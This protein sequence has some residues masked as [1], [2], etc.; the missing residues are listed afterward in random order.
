MAYGAGIWHSPSSG[1]KKPQ[2]IASKLGAIQ[3]KSL[4]TV[5]G[6]YKATPTRRVEVETLIPPIHVYLDDLTARFK[7]RT[8][9]TAADR[10]IQTAC[11]TIRDRLRKRGRGRNRVK[12]PPLTPQQFK[13]V[14]AK[15]WA[16]NADELFPQPPKAGKK[17]LKLRRQ[18]AHWKEEIRGF[19]DNSLAGTK[20]QLDHHILDLHDGLRKAEST[21]I[22]QLRTG[23]TGL[24]AVLRT[25]N[26]PG[27]D[28]GQ[29]KCGQGK[30]T[31]RHV[32]A[33]C[34]L[35]ESR[36]HELRNEDGFIDVTNLLSTEKGAAK[37]ARWMIS[38]GRLSQFAL[39]GE[40]L[41]S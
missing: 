7:E 17:L 13:A 33:H 4:R 30:E 23:Y 15:E 9:D 27:F 1:P 24:A 35:E 19:K 10:V 22:I 20:L 5:A 25:L 26:V 32:L 34:S 18:L 37:A 28:T 12:N 3:N 14:W 39:A 36:R 29:C 21:M 38:S 11:K 2:G 8:T 41:Y 6:T 31:V 16:K 40:L